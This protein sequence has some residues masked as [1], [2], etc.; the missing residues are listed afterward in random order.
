MK[1][2]PIRQ[3]N[4]KAELKLITIKEQCL[5]ALP[6]EKAFELELRFGKAHFD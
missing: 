2:Y 1:K 5:D 4:K 3:F 6:M